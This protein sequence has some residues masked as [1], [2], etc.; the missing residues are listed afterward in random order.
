MIESFPCA[1]A[2]VH[3]E[4]AEPRARV[5]L[6]WMDFYRRNPNVARTCRHF[7]II[8]QTFYRWQRPL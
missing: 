3:G 4:G 1:P 6:D 2:G 5:R 8:R 7:G